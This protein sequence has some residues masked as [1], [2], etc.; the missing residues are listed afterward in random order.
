MVTPPADDDLME[1]FVGTADGAR[2][3]IAVAGNESVAELK[4]R[5]QV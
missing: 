1:I 3:A 2:V 4:R 5:L